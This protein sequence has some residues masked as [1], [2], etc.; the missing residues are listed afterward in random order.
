[1]RAR[2][3]LPAL[4]LSA[5]MTAMAG[6]AAAPPPV[7]D[8]VQAA[9]ESGRAL[10]TPVKQITV[11]AVGDSVTEGNSPDFNKSQLGTLSW[12]SHLPESERFVGGWAK[13]GSTTEMMLANVQHIDADVLVIIAG[14]NDINKL[15]FAQSSANISAIVAKI[16]PKRA[17]ISSIPPYD[18]DPAKAASYNAQMEIFAKAQGW[19]FVDSMAGVRTIDNTYTPGLTADGVHPLEKA[20]DAI[21][22]A[23][24][25]VILA[26]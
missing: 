12:V 19:T 6:C 7:S 15:S 13:K 14:T 16:E 21:G 24:G 10:P 22:Q 11:A 23:I 2:R 8:K 9:Y 17:V 1:M 5:A 4:A 20:A 26:K 25:T 18:P 3:F